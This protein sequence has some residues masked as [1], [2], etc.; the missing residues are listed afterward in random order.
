[1]AQLQSE[2]VLLAK[3]ALCT[4]LICEGVSPETL[5][6]LTTKVDVETAWLY[7]PNKTDCVSPPLP[8]SAM[9]DIP[10]LVCV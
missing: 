6:Q 1:M 8:E 7:P 9:A 3:L 10:P 4:L 2:P 5:K